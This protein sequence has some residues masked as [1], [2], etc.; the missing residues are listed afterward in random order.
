MGEKGVKSALEVQWVNVTYRSVGLLLGF[1]ALVLLGAAGA[2]YYMTRLH[3][4]EEARSAVGRAEKR[5]TEAS[6]LPTTPSLDEIL[7][8]AEVALDEARSELGARSFDDAR[9]AAS[10]SEK[11]SER[12]I[13][14]ASSDEAKSRMVRFD[15]I[16]GDVR[17]KKAGEF[18]W[19]SADQGMVLQIGDQ[20]KTSS[21]GSARLSYFDGTETELKPGSLLEIRDLYEDPVTRVR[22][23]KEKLTWGE[24]KA[25]TR[26]RNVSG[27]YHEVATEKVAARSEGAG[28]F[29]VAY[30]KTS[31]TS[32]F[33]TFA[34]RIE[35]STGS[36]KETVDAGERIKATSVGNLSAKQSLPG[37]PRLT[38]PSDQRVFVFDKPENEKLTLAWE[39]V[40]GIANYELQISD[41]Q[42]FANPLHRSTRTA[43]SAV[44]EGLS[45][46]TYFWKVA[47]VGKSGAVGPFSTTR[48]FRISSQQI[49]DRTD[50]EPPKLD[51]TEFVPVGQMVIINGQTEPGATLWVNNDKI[52][53]FDD[54]SFN[55][56]VKLRQ[57]G[58]N[59][60]VLVAQDNAGNESTVTKS[61]Y[62]EMY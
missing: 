34:G 47:A 32:T 40:G 6:G 9:F 27:S 1:T 15:R 11:L 7:E 39:P 42:L 24:V 51:I 56:V 55:T 5:F 30:D 45:T 43:R 61:T 57:E 25:S 14:L 50:Q 21:T 19:A 37:V 52:E 13:K 35:V 29:R 59:D 62:L 58:R 38:A 8:N 48:H 23:V 10:R 53:V 2:W 26:K 41:R 33:D 4:L 12:A 20:V 49:R 22:R 3:P 31:K 28:E 18:S 36:R 16:E 60:L 54:G 44:L 17:V 46:G